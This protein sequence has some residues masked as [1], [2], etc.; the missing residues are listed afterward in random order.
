MSNIGDTI[1]RTNS[2]QAMS[3]LFSAY[4]DDEPEE[5][6]ADRSTT[7][8]DTTTTTVQDNQVEDH[9]FSGSEEQKEPSEIEQG[10]KIV[11]FNSVSSIFWQDSCF[12]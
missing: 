7:L 3:S 1:G 2:T 4:A 10:D 6:I 5:E 11:K 8:F 9:L 12:V